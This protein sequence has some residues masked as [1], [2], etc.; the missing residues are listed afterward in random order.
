LHPVVDGSLH[1][2]GTVEGRWTSRNIMRDTSGIGC[3]WAGQVFSLRYL[4]EGAMELASCLG[5]IPH[6]DQAGCLIR[7][8]H[9]LPLRTA[10][11]YIYWHL[12]CESSVRPVTTVV[13]N[14]H[15]VA[16]SSFVLSFIAVRPGTRRFEGR[17]GFAGCVCC[18]ASH[19]RG[20]SSRGAYRRAAVSTRGIGGAAARGLGRYLL[21][22]QSSGGVNSGK[23]DMRGGG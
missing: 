8:G 3:G 11:R 12:H 22:E 14:I 5:G 18:Q 16:G 2:I 6:V 10:L 20:V 7:G 1:M 21:Q 9:S 4:K 19:R 23:R 13:G 17:G 15:S